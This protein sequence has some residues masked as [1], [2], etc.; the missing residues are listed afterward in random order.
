MKVFALAI[1]FVTVCCLEGGLV[2]RQA[3]SQ[4][5]IPAIEQF[6]QFSQSLKQ[7]LPQDLF[8]QEKFTE[9]RTQA[10]A[11]LQRV[12]EH[13]KPFTDQLAGTITEFF[14]GLADSFKTPAQ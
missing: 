6:Q 11:G 3:E 12:H 9:L 4:A 5:Q 1:L 8:T 2:K 14:S 13:V 7:Y 10:E